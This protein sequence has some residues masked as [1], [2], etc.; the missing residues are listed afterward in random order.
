MCV[1]LF[2]CLSVLNGFQNH[3]SIHREILQ[4]LLRK[5][6][7]DLRTDELF[8]FIWLNTMKSQ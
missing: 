6:S 2:V 4:F 7:L 3:T 5:T 8:L 1:C